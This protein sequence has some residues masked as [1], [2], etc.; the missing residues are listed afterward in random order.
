MDKAVAD[1]LRLHDYV[2][3]DVSPHGGCGVVY[4]RSE[5]ITDRDPHEL[6]HT[7]LLQMMT[8]LDIAGVPGPEGNVLTVYLDHAVLDRGA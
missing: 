8:T 2:V 4:K 1:I 3:S 7:L 6:A 5:S